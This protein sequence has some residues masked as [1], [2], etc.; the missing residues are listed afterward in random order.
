MHESKCFCESNSGDKSKHKLKF[1][2]TSH[3]KSC[4]SYNNFKKMLDKYDPL[5]SS[6]SDSEA[7]IKEVKLS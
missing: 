4:G 3:E 1:P 7:S 2:N 6:D 5:S